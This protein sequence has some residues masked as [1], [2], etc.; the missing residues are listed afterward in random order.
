MIGVRLII[1][2]ASIGLLSCVTPPQGV[3]TEGLAIDDPRDYETIVLQRELRLFPDAERESPLFRFEQRLVDGAR[4]GPGREALRAALYGGQAA[5]DYATAT[6]GRLSAEYAELAEVARASLDPASGSPG[7]SFSWEYLEESR[8]L[9]GAANA[10]GL[11]TLRYVF[12][13][14]A[15]GLSERR[16]AIM[17]LGTGRLLGPEDLVRSPGD[18]SL[19]LEAEAALRL[20][21]GLTPGTPLSEG[22]LFEDSLS[23]LPSAVG[24]SALGLVLHWDQYEIGPYALGPIEVTIP[25]ERVRPY[26]S[27]RAIEIVSALSR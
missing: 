16:F 4:P 13:G 18:A 17:D 11:E 1:S 22:G 20:E 14:G 6:L 21:R 12:Q 2:I 10:L 24:L 8:L 15:H 25:L 26:L 7:A 27:A 19:L 5:E 9:W 3:G 23:A